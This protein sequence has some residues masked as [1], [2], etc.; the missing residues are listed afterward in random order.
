M[1]NLLLRIIINI[2]LELL[3]FLRYITMSR[4]NISLVFLRTKIRKIGAKNRQLPKNTPTDKVGNVKRK[5][6][7]CY[8]LTAEKMSRPKPLVAL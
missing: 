3:L 1:I 7:I 5:A 2:L 8:E 6:Y 4:I